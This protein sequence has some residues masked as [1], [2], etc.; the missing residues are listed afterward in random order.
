MRK[1]IAGLSLFALGAA[2]IVA[3]P[4]SVQPVSRCD[5]KWWKERFEKKQELVSQ[6]GWEVVFLGD[7]I[8]QGWESHGKDIWLE[9]FTP[10]RVLNLGYSGDRTEHVAWRV[11][12]G[13]FDGYKPKL[14][15]LMIGTNNTGHR[16]LAQESPEETAA[17]IKL[18]LENLRRKAPESKVLLLAIFPR[19]NQPHD[20]MRQRNN[21]VN[22]IIKE[23]A[24]GTH[25][26]WM[27]I[28]QQML[29]PDGTLDKEMMPDFLHPRQKGYAVWANRVLPVI[30]AAV[31]R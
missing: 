27:D 15:I 2:T 24:D 17:G 8:T 5:V 30:K 10:Y 4:L 29:E 16:P 9:S 23:Y 3:Q 19:G 28:N 13:E 14:I 12:N 6:G 26:V 20:K 11:Q 22:E 7:S 21:R 1:L 18:I 31:G 25:V